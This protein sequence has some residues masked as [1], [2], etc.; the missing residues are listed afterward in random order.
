[1]KDFIG[2]FLKNLFVDEG[3]QA[4]SEQLLEHDALADLLPYCV[5]DDDDMLYHNQDTTGFILEIDPQTRGHEIMANVHS[6]ILQSFP[7]V[8]GFQV[9]SWTSPDI[10]AHL[11]AWSRERVVGNEISEEVAAARGEFLLNKAFGTEH[12]IKDV[13]HNKRVFFCAWVEGDDPSYS[14][15]ASLREFRTNLESA[16]LLR[17]GQG[18]SPSQLITVLREILCSESWGSIDGISYDSERPL[19]VQVPQSPLTVHPDFMEVVGDRNVSITG[20]TVQRYPREWYSDLGHLFFGEPEKITDR[21]HG[22]VLMSL[23]GQSIPHQKAGQSI[24]S[25]QASMEHS[26][27]TGMNKFTHDFKGKQDEYNQ[28]AQEVETGERLF[29]TVFSV[30]SY[31][32]GDGT[33]AKSAGKEIEKIFRQVGMPLRHEKFLQLPVF[34]AAMPLG[35]NKKYI[36]KLKHLSRTRLMKAKVMTTIAPV[37]GEFKGNSAGSGMLLTGR[38]GQIFTWDNFQSTGNYNV[39]VVG[40]SGAGKS[41]FMQD[42]V[43]CIVA[44]GGRALVID[45]G[46]SFENSCKIQ[47]GTHISF[48]G[49]QQLRLNPFSLF[50]EEQMKLQEYKTDAIELVVNI[51][52]SMAQLGED[53]L[54][55]VKGIEEE[56]IRGSINYVWDEKG[57]K[58]DISDVLADLQDEAKNE[59]RL[60]DVC[61]KIQNFARGGIYGDYFHGPANISLDSNLTVVELSDIKGIPV[62]E[63]V[64]LQMIMFLGTELM[65]KTD[66]SEPVVIL[67]D[68]A[69]DL[70]KGPTTAKF[71]EGVVRRARKYTGSLVTGTQSI[72][73]YY[74][75]PAAGVC[76]ENSDFNIFLAQKPATID[77]LLE[78]KKLG[79]GQG[80][81]K[82]LKSLQSVKG[83]FSELAIRGPEGWAFGRLALDP[84]SL[85]I[86]SSKGSTVV[87]IRKRQQQGMTLAEAL[88]DVVASGEVQ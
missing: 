31:T 3:V 42:M 84:L 15:K 18:L 46:Y 1:M 71:L 41:V 22:P 55:R 57:P 83:Q 9:V 78:E 20:A 45:D 13:P 10:T 28:L 14:V 24:L 37:H 30:F 73:D 62:L 52:A 35:A 76:L 43:N 51:V 29:D 79:V 66:R 85:A 54:T 67:I 17:P 88:R 19:N 2:D 80:V 75:N 4:P 82:R 65:Y 48:D 77:R 53:T 32:E 58:G 49:S 68:E 5:Y 59:P 39:S 16:L 36:E 12:V 27:K 21:P 11:G 26:A 50:D 56:A 8:G 70:L 6:A 81:A 25:K 63:Q 23:T 87:A 47:G 44:N 64:V 34:L 69:W 72:Q 40:K 38:Q 33:D 7:S 60:R 86:Y 74:D 61:A